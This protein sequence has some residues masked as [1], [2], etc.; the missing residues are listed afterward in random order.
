[1]SSSRLNIR[2]LV[3]FDGTIVP[4]DVTDHVLGTF[5]DPSWLELEKAWQSGKMNSR[6]CM[7]AQVDLIRAT[8]SDIARAVSERDIDPA[9]PEFVARCKAHGMEV[10]VVSD[11][12]DL[13]IETTLKR[14]GLDL[15]YFANSLE[16]LGGDRWK[17]G[18]PNSSDDCTKRAG[19]CKCQRLADGATRTVVIGDGRSDFCVAAKSD[20]VLSKS[21][22]TNHCVSQGLRHIAISG[23]ADVVRTFDS[24]TVEALMAPRRQSLP[25][26]AIPHAGLDLSKR[27][28]HLH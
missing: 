1:M 27:Q 24:W 16:W 6:D 13:A 22:L 5:A 10:T 18:F 8:P 2:V 21:S 7:A 17:L 26:R 14:A 28:S 23:F 9:F 11:G 12:F 20:L 19:H 15:P 3:D 25:R 4:G